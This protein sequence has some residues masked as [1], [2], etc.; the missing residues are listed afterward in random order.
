MNTHRED[1]TT[2]MQRIKLRESQGQSFTGLSDAEWSQILWA[3]N[4]YDCAKSK[5]EELNDQ[6]KVTARADLDFEF[7]RMKDRVDLV[8]NETRGIEIDKDD[9]LHVEYGIDGPRVALLNRPRK[10]R[11]TT[12]SGTVVDDVDGVCIKAQA[13][14]KDAESGETIYGSPDDGEFIHL[15]N[16]EYA[17]VFRFVTAKPNDRVGRGIGFHKSK[18]QKSGADPSIYPG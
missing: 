11:A 9:L 12:I 16:S 1:F 4:L 14:L 13:V 10:T 17:I 7:W 3:H 5:F 18:Q 6:D 8:L 2:Q 15:G